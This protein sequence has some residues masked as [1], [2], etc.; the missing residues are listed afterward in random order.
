MKVISIAAVLSLVLLSAV[1]ERA[2]NLATNEIKYRARVTRDLQET[3]YVLANEGRLAQ[4]F[5]NLLI[6]AAHAIDKGD[7]E[8]N[9]ILVRVWHD[10]DEVLA[11]VKDTGKGIDPAHLPYVFEPFFTT[12]E[13]GLGT[14]LGLYIS[15]N[16]VSSLGGRL[17]VESTVGRGTRF[18]LTLPS[19]EP[20]APR[21]TAAPCHEHVLFARR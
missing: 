13:R 9:E 18:V 8:G 10:G 20:L 3:P 11:E 21:P 2:V 5:L 16:I 19:A 15:K 6:N 17:D 12:K 7:P 4:V 14:G 1:V